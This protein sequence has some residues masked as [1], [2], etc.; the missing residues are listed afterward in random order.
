MVRVASC[1]ENP[2]PQTMAILSCE[3]LRCTLSIQPTI[4]S[5][6]TRSVQGC[7]IKDDGDACLVSRLDLLK[8]CLTKGD[9]E[10]AAE[11]ETH[12]KR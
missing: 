5:P 1:Q 7:V 9:D 6:E 8:R 3:P 2:N 12:R 4:V 10:D 11:I